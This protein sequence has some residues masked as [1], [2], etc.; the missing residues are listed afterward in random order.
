MAGFASIDNSGRKDLNSSKYIGAVD[1][2]SVDMS[3]LFRK[4]SAVISTLL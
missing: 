2:F 4:Y 1:N 3:D